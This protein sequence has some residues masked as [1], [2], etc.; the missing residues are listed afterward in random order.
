MNLDIEYMLNTNTNIL[1]EPYLLN[2]NNIVYIIKNKNII[3]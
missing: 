3:L 1:F 2:K